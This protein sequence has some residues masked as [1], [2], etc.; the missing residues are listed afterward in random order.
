VRRTG[1]TAHA[2]L[3]LLALRPTWS[4]YELT[5]QLRRNMRFFWPRAESRIY[6]EAKALVD[7]GWAEAEPVHY[8][9]RSRTVYGITPAGRRAL[10]SWLA[11]RPRG[12]ALECEP[13]LRVF[14]GTLS[15]RE[16]LLAAVE[17]VRADGDA[18][19]DVGRRVSSEYLSGTAPFQDEVQVRALVFD[20]LSCHAL[21]LREWA[22]RTER[23]LS[24]WPRQDDEQRI[25]VALETIDSVR[26]TYPDR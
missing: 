10:R 15:D 3:G 21:M 14:L 20:F 19:L 23:T 9:K 24:D 12:T 17:Q 18:I 4:T 26:K 16:H 11:T 25:A 7:R 22:D 2:I 1:T 13:L 8:G 6:A 5:Q